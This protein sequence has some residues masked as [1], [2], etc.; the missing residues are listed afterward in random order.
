MPTSSLV[1]DLFSPVSFPGFLRD[2]FEKK[3]LLVR[4]REDRFDGVLSLAG[5]DQVLTAGYLR[6][7]QVKLVSGG[8]DVPTERYVHGDWS[9]GMI[10]IEGLFAE[11]ADGATIIINYLHRHWRPLSYFCRELEQLLSLAV[12]AN[13]YLTPRFSQGFDVHYDSHD[14]IVLQIAGEKN[15]RLYGSPMYLPGPQQPYRAN[16]LDVGRVQQ[17]C[18][19]RA[20]DALYIPR[21]YLHD[22][23]ASIEPSL[24]VTV[25]L[26][27]TTWGDVL[28]EAAKMLARNENA[29]RRS[30]PT[31]FAVR[32]S[33]PRELRRQAR[34]LRK[35]AS[36]R[37]PVDQALH[38]MTDRFLSL[39]PQFL[40]Q[41]FLDMQK[42]W[43]VQAGTTLVRR[44]GIVFR[45]L[46][47]GGQV[48]L[49]F[50]RKKIL[51]PR[52]VAPALKYIT[53]VEGEF[54]PANVPGDLSEDSKVLLCRRLMREGFLRTVQ[55]QPPQRTSAVAKGR[56]A[57]K[58][59]LRVLK[60]EAIIV[61]RQASRGPK[62]DTD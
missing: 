18:T 19:L 46:R 43:C 13:I 15:W 51:L 56:T 31:N 41:H 27:S 44:Q 10:D 35:L 57:V 6:Y 50:Y 32:N 55:T 47:E 5:I 33:S 28:V 61:Q 36:T 58:H 52:F 30:L 53:K 2:Y 22:A 38:A 29:L 14:V 45:E 9:A 39:R 62:P 26:L 21:G 1:Q 37:L 23:T 59:G 42:P 60:E 24:H 7:P 12:Q 34:Q 8:Q 40:E 48:G 11:H 17:K 3:P 20:G 16:A 54:R 49:Q 25:G 4:G